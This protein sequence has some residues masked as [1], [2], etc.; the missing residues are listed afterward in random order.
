MGI[1]KITLLDGTEVTMPRPTMK[2]WCRVAEYDETEKGEWGIV[3]LM[4]EHSKIIAEMFGLESPEVIDPADVLPMYVEAASYVIGI[5]NEKL[6][7]LPK[8][9]EPGTDEK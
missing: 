3:K 6:K 8:N 5:A 1:P 4:D 2:M 7:K 9:A